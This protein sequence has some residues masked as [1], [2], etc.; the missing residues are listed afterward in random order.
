[1]AEERRGRR[2]LIAPDAESLRER[3]ARALDVGQRTGGARL[4]HLSHTASKLLAVG[5]DLREQA[6]ELL[7]RAPNL[8]VRRK[9]LCRSAKSSGLTRARRAERVVDL[10]RSG[11]RLLR[12]GDLA[13]AACDE[14]RERLL[15]LA[16]RGC[17]HRVDTAR[18]DARVCVAEALQ[19]LVDLT[20]HRLVGLG[21]IDEEQHSPRTLEI[22]QQFDRRRRKA[23]RTRLGGIRLDAHRR[24]R[25]Q[26]DHRA[27][28]RD[29]GDDEGRCLDPTRDAR[30]DPM[31]AAV[32]DPLE[33]HGGCREPDADDCR[34]VDDPAAVEE[35]ER[36][37]LEPTERI[38]SR[39]GGSPFDGKHADKQP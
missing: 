38:R 32:A 4:R 25:E 6:G 35:P 2:E 3:A 11:D 39:C 36:E 9:L 17:I 31:R 21:R 26:R 18:I 15:E 37:P 34:E 5:R 12:A 24:R 27:R 1:M 30:A 16:G 13:L 23:V 29:A 28:K 33:R 19:D 22:L 7:E 8:V 10:E 14:V 20:E